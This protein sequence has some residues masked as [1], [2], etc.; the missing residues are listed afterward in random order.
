MSCLPFP[1]LS[2]AFK[3]EAT[4]SAGPNE[5]SAAPEPTESP[6]ESYERYLWKNAE[7]N[8]TLREVRKAGHAAI[9]LG[10]SLPYGEFAV[11]KPNESEC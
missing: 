6:R 3:A 11:I 4:T 8:Q 10:E 9:Q 2:T 5:P 7:R 1:P